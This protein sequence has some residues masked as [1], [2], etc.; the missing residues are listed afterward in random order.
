MP[1]I[2]LSG[3]KLKKMNRTGHLLGDKGD[4]D[5]ILNAQQW[6]VQFSKHIPLTFIQEAGILNSLTITMKCANQK[7]TMIVIIG[8]TTSGILV[9]FILMV[10]KCPDQRK[11]SLQ[12]D[13]FLKNIHPDN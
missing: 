11:I 10:S 1:R 13:K 8:S 7:H 6:Q 2:L 5:G 4:L 3:R 12:S 9:T